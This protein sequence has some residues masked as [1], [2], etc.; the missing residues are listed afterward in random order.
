ML[1][2]CSNLCPPKNNAQLRRGNCQVNGSES[3]V[4]VYL[5]RSLTSSHC[6]SLPGTCVY[7]E[8]VV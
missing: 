6:F 8:L 5:E 1:V 2:M 7:Y 4:K 3:D